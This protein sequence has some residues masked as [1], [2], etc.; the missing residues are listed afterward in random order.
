MG[1]VAFSDETPPGAASLSAEY[2]Q[3]T[4][5]QSPTADAS[6]AWIGEI[7]PFASD[8]SARSFLHEIEAGNQIWIAGGRV[9]DSLPS[10]SHWADPLLVN[11]AAQ[12][13]LLI[14]I[15]RAPAHPRAY[16]LRP[17][18]EEHYAIVHPHPRYDQQIEWDGQKTPGLCVYSAPEFR[19]KPERALIPQYLDQLTLYAARHLVWLRTRQLVSGTPPRDGIVLR[20][21]MPGEPLFNDKPRLVRPASS[22]RKAICEYWRGYWPGRTAYA[23]NPVTH[24]KRLKP[25]GECWCGSGAAYQACHR[26]S[27]AKGAAA[28]ARAAVC[29]ASSN[30]LEPLPVRGN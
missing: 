18:F 26:S 28:R 27:D 8:E 17:L 19:Y 14:L 23:F 22:E 11:M 25:E 15:Q 7:Q 12:C 2:P 3:F 5:V 9:R 24:L 1:P 4:R 16:L 20:T 13:R 6:S 21:L 29:I 10:G 30:H